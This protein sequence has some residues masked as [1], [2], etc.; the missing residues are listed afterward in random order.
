MYS[1]KTAL[2]GDAVSLRR[3]DENE[4]ALALRADGMIVNA[5]AGPSFAATR[6][7]LVGMVTI[8]NNAGRS[9]EDKGGAFVHLRLHHDVRGGLYQYGENPL[10]LHPYLEP[11]WQAAYDRL[12]REHV[13]QPFSTPR[14]NW[15]C[16]DR[17]LD[18]DG[19]V[20]TRRAS[21]TIKADA[22]ALL[23][24]DLETHPAAADGRLEIWVGARVGPGFTGD[25]A[26]VMQANELVPEGSSWFGLADHEN[27]VLLGLLTVNMTTGDTNRVFNFIPFEPSRGA[28][29][30]DGLS[31]LLNELR[32][33]GLNPV[34]V[35]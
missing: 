4:A 15:L 11:T 9:P 16:L 17:A 21:F 8:S 13:T 30:L 20:I 22:P 33:A 10:E 29:M 7:A 34:P 26:L 2:S 1:T 28:G 14:D 5:D 27:A 35:G 19:D 31:G 23:E 24:I 6:A 18:S 12:E 32:A 25:A 3:L